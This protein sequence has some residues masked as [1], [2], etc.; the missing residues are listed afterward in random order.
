M[1]LQSTS[2]SRE[3]GQPSLSSDTFQHREFQTSM[4]QACQADV[5]EAH[6]EALDPT[7]PMPSVAH[8]FFVPDRP[9]ATAAFFLLQAGILSGRSSD[10][11]GDQQ[12]HVPAAGVPD[13]DGPGPSGPCFWNTPRGYGH[14][15]PHAFCGSFLV[16]SRHTSCYSSLF[17]CFAGRYFSGRNLDIPVG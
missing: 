4:A 1:S 9:P 14:H 13:F 3:L 11:P 7:G 2:G 8:S 12:T 15:R 17:L 10:I 5:P 16:C 6:L